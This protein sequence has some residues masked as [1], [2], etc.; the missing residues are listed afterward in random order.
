MSPI[1]INILAV[2]AGLFIGGIVNASIVTL[3]SNLILPPEGVDPNDI[4]TMKA[5]ADQYGI[6][7]FIVPFLA[8]GLGTLAGAF[9][10]VKLAISN[11]KILAYTIAV[12]FSIGGAIMAFLLPEF[13][14]YS[15]VDLL[16][17]YFPMAIIGLSLARNKND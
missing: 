14:M 1:V 16:L 8:H 7:H 5:H 2:I 17:A 10:T 11:H 3:G 12:F 4:A 13:W 6:K 15:I 9:I